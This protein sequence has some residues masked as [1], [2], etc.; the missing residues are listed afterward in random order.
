[1]CN[2]N[3]GISEMKISK[4][5]PDY[6]ISTYSESIKKYENGQFSINTLYPDG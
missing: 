2:V 5:G 4:Q 3:Y 1:V 6:I